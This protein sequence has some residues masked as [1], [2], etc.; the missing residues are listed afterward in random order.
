[1]ATLVSISNMALT[2]LGH[3]TINS[4]DQGVE[5]ARKC[6]LLIQ[7]AID[8]VLRAYNWN[9]ATKRAALTRSGTDPSFGY[10]YQ[11]ALP[12]D[13]LRVIRMEEASYDFKIEGRLLLTN[14]TTAKIIYICRILVGE[15]DSLLSQAI[16]ARLGLDLSYGLS[17]S[18][19]MQETMAK[20]YAGKLQEAQQI[21]AQEGIPYDLETTTWL[22]ARQ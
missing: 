3:N 9:C 16:A 15:M 14:E 18:N 7:P 20:L 2:H 21:D 12:L 1:M 22:D 13:C 11:F 8:A 10:D 19:S 5:A 6:K 17:N 4:M